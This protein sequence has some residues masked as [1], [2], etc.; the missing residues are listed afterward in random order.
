MEA[1][2]SEVAHAWGW[3]AGQAVNQN[4]LFI[5]T[6]GWVKFNMADRMDIRLPLLLNQCIK[7]SKGLIWFQHNQPFPW[8]SEGNLTV[9]GEILSMSNITRAYSGD[10]VCNADNGVGRYPVRESI[11]LDVLCKYSSFSFAYILF[12]QLLYLI[13]N[14]THFSKAFNQYYNVI[15]FKD[16]FIFRPSRGVHRKSMDSFQGGWDCYISVS[17]L[18]ES[19][20]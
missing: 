10:Y 15:I 9:P 13:E 7:Y 18:L 20:S 17:G 14:S 3:S 6:E 8:G 11:T 12:M 4:Q 1:S 16:L 5:G 19:S 2:Q